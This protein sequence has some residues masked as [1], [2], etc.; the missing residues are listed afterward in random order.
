MKQIL[1]LFILVVGCSIA[2]SQQS[3]NLPLFSHKETLKLM[4]TRFEI[5]AMGSSK[6]IAEDAVKKSIQEIQRIESLISSWDPNS[7]TSLINKNAGKQAVIVDEELVQLI[8]RSIKVSNLSNGAFDIS[9]AGIESIYTFDKKDKSLPSDSII[10]KSI[11][12]IGFNDI[13]INHTAST[14]YL[15]KEGMRIGFGGIG[16]GYAANKA[17]QLMKSLDGIA[18]GVVNAAGDLMV[19]GENGKNSQ[20]PIQISDPADPSKSIGWLQINNTSVVTSGNYEKYFLSN[21]QR[22]AHIINPK[23]GIPTT[24]IKSAT[25]VCPDA[26]LGDALATTLFVLGPDDAIAFI[27]SLRNIEAL[28]ITD[29][30]KIHTSSHLQLNTL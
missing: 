5:T 15:T 26:E 12:L 29:D 11:A 22:Y 3:E 16:K 13:K 4:G 25:I 1:I 17:V 10:R 21:G 24:G 30:N 8:D 2:W 23:T 19:W 20:W 6:I 18:G 14:V 9:F 7:Q 28:I 27:N